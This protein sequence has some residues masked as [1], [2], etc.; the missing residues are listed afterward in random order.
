MLC[1]CNFGSTSGWSDGKRQGFF[2]FTID[3]E[4]SVDKIPFT[5]TIEGD[6]NGIITDLGADTF[7]IPV[8]R[9]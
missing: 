7:V 6:I 9:Q 2:R 5:L 4:I 1:D 8:K 3:P